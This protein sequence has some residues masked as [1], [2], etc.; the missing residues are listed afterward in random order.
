MSFVPPAVG[1]LT[2]LESR[3][4]RYLKAVGNVASRILGTERLQPREHCDPLFQ[5]H[6]S[7]VSQFAGELRLSNQ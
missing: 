6:Q 1:G 2:G 5:L 7:R 3:G 4:S